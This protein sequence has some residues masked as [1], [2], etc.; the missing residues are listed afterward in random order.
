MI[1]NIKGLLKIKDEIGDI[2]QKI[3][4]NKTAVDELTKNMSSFRIELEQAN[5]AQSEMM[6]ELKNQLTSLSDFRNGLENELY[7]FKL[8]KNELQRKVLLK[9]EEELNKELKAQMENMGKEASNYE[10]L[11]MKVA[12]T[13]AKTEKLM[14]EMDRLVEISS[15]I[16]AKD[17]EMEKFAKQLLDMDKEK[18]ELMKKIDTLE[19][20]LAQMQRRR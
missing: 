7:E 17:F 2:Q 13:A 3:D 8:L 18:L 16:R 19:R 11:K 9:F 14:Q 20:L 6:A 4:V 12:A 15:K 10:E 1:D 5:K